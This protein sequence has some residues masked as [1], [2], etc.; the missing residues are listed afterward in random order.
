M[1]QQ[2][3]DV[4]LIHGDCL[5]V[6][7]SLAA[8]TV[9]MIFADLPYAVTAAPW[10]VATDLRKL[11]RSFDAVL[12]QNNTIIFTAVQPFAT[13][14]I[15]SNRSAFRYDIVWHKARCSNF[16]Q[17]KKR[18][19]RQHELILI[20]G[21]KQSTYNP[22]KVAGRVRTDGYKQRADIFHSNETNYRHNGTGLKN[23]TTVLK[24]S[25]GDTMNSRLMRMHPTQKPVAL[26]S[27]LISTYTNSGDTILDPVAGSATTAIAAMR[28][29]NRKVICIEKDPVYF[30]AMVK[31]VTDERAKLGMEP[32]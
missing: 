19:M 20:F 27:W 12:M 17:A 30:E 31:R 6:I 11:W 16:Y 9:A 7:P 10:D 14:L 18:P 1:R 21:H 29:G 3:G 15:I 25:E 22:Q 13:D 24:V 5:D 8:G 4:T 2:I 26:L 23:P 28:V 32:M